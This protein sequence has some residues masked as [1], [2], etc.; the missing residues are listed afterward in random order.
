MMKKLTNIEQIQ[1]VCSEGD[2]KGAQIFKEN[3]LKNTQD[4]TIHPVP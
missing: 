1:M 3:T 4:K 2:K